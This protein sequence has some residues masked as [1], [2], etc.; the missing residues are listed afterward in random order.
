[1][2]QLIAIAFLSGAAVR[3]QPG[4]QPF[5]ELTPEEQ[6]HGY[7]LLSTEM[8]RRGGSIRNVYSA[9]LLCFGQSCLLLRVPRGHG[10]VTLLALEQQRLK[11]M[12]WAIDHQDHCSIATK[13]VAFHSGGSISRG[14]HLQDIAL[15]LRFAFE[16]RLLDGSLLP[17]IR[18]EGGCRGLI[19]AI[20]TEIARDVDIA[21]AIVDGD[22]AG[23][24]D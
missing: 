18:S 10:S 19:R 4:A 6:K 2:R 5:N 21:L 17:G 7:T 3:A 15:P 23:L 14:C 16:A 24:D 9:S 20:V 12:P 8:A 22:R 13:T 11:Y 1:M